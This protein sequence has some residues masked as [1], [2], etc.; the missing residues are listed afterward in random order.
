MSTSNPRAL[1]ATPAVGLAAADHL[2]TRHQT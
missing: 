1:A 2:E